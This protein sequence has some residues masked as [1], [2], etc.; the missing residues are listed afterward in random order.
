[1]AA[2]MQYAVLPAAGSF[3]LG[4]AD[5]S[6]QALHDGLINPVG[7]ALWVVLAAYLLFGASLGLFEDV[8]DRMQVE[9]W[10]RL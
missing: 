4:R 10:S 8:A 6:P 2:I 1:M 7:F 9:R 3:I 5:I